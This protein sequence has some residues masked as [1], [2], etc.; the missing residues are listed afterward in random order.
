MLKIVK[1]IGGLGIIIFAILIVASNI[2]KKQDSTFVFDIPDISKVYVIDGDNGSIMEINDKNDINTLVEYMKNIEFI[3]EGNT[4]PWGGYSYNIKFA[5]G[6]AKET[7]YIFGT[8]HVTV[9]NCNYSY[10]NANK[11]SLEKLWT[12]M[13][14]SSF[15]QSNE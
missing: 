3:K 1:Y 9:D 11:I 6:N 15:V 12:E 8:N 7:Q 2:I 10:T 5:D 4:N 14:S 13:K